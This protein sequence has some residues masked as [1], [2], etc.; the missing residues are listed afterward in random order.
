MLN[1]NNPIVQVKTDTT[2]E[3]ILSIFVL[4]KRSTNL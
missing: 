3:N 4:V 1:K 2:A